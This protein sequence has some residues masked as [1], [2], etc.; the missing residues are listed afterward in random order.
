MVKISQLFPDPREFENS[1][2]HDFHSDMLKKLLC[3]DSMFRCSKQT[4]GTLF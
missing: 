1:I 4:N 3:T 2:N